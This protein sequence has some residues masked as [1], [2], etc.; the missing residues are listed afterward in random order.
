MN[1]L[2][3]HLDG[4]LPLAA[5]ASERP[6][7]IVHCFRAPV[8]GLFRHVCDLAEIQKKKGH[9][10]GIVCDSSTGGDFEGTILERIAPMLSLGIHRFPMR[11]EISPADVAATWR[12]T[13]EIRA[14][15]PDVLHAHGAKGGA[16]ARLIGTLLRATGSPVTRIY[17]PHGGSLQFDP[18]TNAGRVFFAFE[19]ILSSMTDAFIFVSQ[20][21]EDAFV[22]KIGRPRAPM[23]VALNGLRAEEFVP[24]TPNADARDFLFIGLMRP[25][26]GPEEFIRALAIVRDRTGRAPTA[27]MVGG[28]DEKP[29]YEKMVR[30]LGLSEA[31][32]FR[33]PMPP[34]EAFALARVVVAPS[35]HESLPYLILESI[36]AGMPTLTTRVGGLAEV[37]GPDADDLLP[38]NDAERLADAMMQSLANP[39]DAAAVATRVRAYIR[40]RFSVEAMAAT[41][42]R[43][44]R[45]VVAA[46]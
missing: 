46:R 23:T 39:A 38:P 40:P 21:E 18:K 10:V 2:A 30:D 44:Y 27:W 7:R 12:A 31:V 41:I 34:R 13:R 14:L 24:V 28:G 3:P 1:Q 35:R 26:K 16:Y 42:C 22:A 20:Y 37:F 33:A 43:T 8:G 36:A 11:R 29:V 5:G 4:A 6:L 45:Q 9:Q 15:K 32:T 19:R 17:T 25:L